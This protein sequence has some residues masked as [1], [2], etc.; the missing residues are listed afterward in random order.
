MRAGVRSRNRRDTGVTR[1][2]ARLPH[3]SDGYRKIR[4]ELLDAEIA[5][6]EQTIAVAALR[7]ELPLDTVV[8]DY[9]FERGPAD[10]DRDEPVE[11]VHL[12]EL[13]T[14][15]DKPLIVYHFMYGEA[16]SQP[17]PMCS[18]WLDGFNGIVRHV[19]QRASL[20]VVAAAP[21]A[22]LRGYA[23]HRGWSNL[24]LL[25]SASC[26]FKADLQT[27]T[28][29]GGQRPAISVFSKADDGTVRHFYT[30]EA[31]L[32]ENTWGGL[33]PYCPV[34]NLFDLTPPGRGNWTPQ[35]EYH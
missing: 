6:R 3:E 15:P 14:D 35:L 24:P 4:Q 33:D 8:D 25:S 10:L 32:D 27:Q 17:C 30:G 12:S 5:L 23:R 19:T 2:V 18:M 16:Q 31:T 22:Q 13:F 26:T 1:I 21:I 29:E 7:R 34:W 20:V 9:V 28:P 11:Q